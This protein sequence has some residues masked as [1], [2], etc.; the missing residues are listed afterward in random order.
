MQLLVLGIFLGP[1]PPWK[2]V[3]REV[4][5]FVATSSGGAVLFALEYGKLEC[6]VGACAA[7]KDD[8]HTLGRLE[9]CAPRR[10]DGVLV[11]ATDAVCGAGYTLARGLVVFDGRDPDTLAHELGHLWGAG[12]AGVEGGEGWDAVYGDVSSVMGYSGLGRPLLERDYSAPEKVLFGWALPPVP[13]AGEWTTLGT[14]CLGSAHPVALRLRGGLLLSWRP[15]RGCAPE[16]KTT[17]PKLFVHR[18][19]SPTGT[20]LVWSGVSPKHANELGLRLA[21]TQSGSPDLLLVRV[22]D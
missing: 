12:H 18:W 17:Q 9:A 21:W 8:W 3:A 7:A 1:P 16:N 20:I 2:E 5:G 6:D 22:R 15:A 19:P 14:T 11:I 13:A 10:V 4:V